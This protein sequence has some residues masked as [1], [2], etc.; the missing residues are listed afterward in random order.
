MFKIEYFTSDGFS[1]QYI[2]KDGYVTLDNLNK[3]V[4]RYYESTN[5]IPEN[6][7]LDNNLYKSLMKLLSDHYLSNFHTNSNG[8]MVFSF[9]STVGNV[10]VISKPNSYIRM[11]AGS[12]QEYIDND[13]G[14]IFEEEVLS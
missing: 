1:I 11:L 6:V 12:E 8:S 10:K 7:F 4:L 9:W 3:L 2:L 5:R 13:V 14:R